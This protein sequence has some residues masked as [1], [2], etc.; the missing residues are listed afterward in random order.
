MAQQGGLDCS[1][2]CPDRSWRAD[3]ALEI[4]IEAHKGT[5]VRILVEGTLNRG[6]GANLVSVVKELIDEGKCDF[7]IVTSDLRLTDGESSGVMAGPGPLV[8]QFGGRLAWRMGHGSD[9]SFGG[10]LS[11]V[12]A[13]ATASSSGPS[14]CG[15]LRRS[16][17]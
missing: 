14:S 17:V 16:T 6:T 7:E 13:G 2:Y 1:P 5:A 12:S 10:R 4:W 9:I 11:E 8:Q 15:P 3:V